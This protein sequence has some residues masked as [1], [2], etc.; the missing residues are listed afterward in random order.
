MACHTTRRARRDGE[1]PGYAGQ[2]SEAKRAAVSEWLTEKKLDETD[3]LGAAA[4][5]AACRGGLTPPS[6]ARATEPRL[7]TVS[8]ESLLVY[9]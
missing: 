3:P 2:S 7:G 5:L 6:L 4:L 1:R 8:A 9:Q